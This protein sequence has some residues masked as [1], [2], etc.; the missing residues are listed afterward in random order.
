[1]TSTD[2]ILSVT[3]FV[4]FDT[5]A[6]GNIQVHPEQITLSEFRDALAALHFN[7]TWDGDDRQASIS[8]CN[9]MGQRVD[10]ATAMV[11]P[12]TDDPSSENN[13]LVLVVGFAPG[14]WRVD[15]TSAA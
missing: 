15:I 5:V 3:C 2:V 8:V 13:P 12:G 10:G 7:C 11:L 6:C 4:Y 9:D 1:M 14:H